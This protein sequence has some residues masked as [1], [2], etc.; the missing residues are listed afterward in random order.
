MLIACG[1][2]G[3]SEQG[4]SSSS[5]LISVLILSLEIR[6]LVLD[7]DEANELVIAGADVTAAV[8]VLVSSVEPAVD[9]PV[10]MLLAIVVAVSVVNAGKPSDFVI[11]V[12]ESI[13]VFKPPGIL[14]SVAAVDEATVVNV[15]L[16]VVIVDTAMDDAVSPLLISLAKET[17]GTN[18]TDEP[19]VVAIEFDVVKASVDV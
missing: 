17:G 8:T 11:K 9:P 10:F 18:A 1:G 2:T 5:C 6:A 15:E 3:I 13:G 14:L 19:A 4:I 16:M 7:N 12:F